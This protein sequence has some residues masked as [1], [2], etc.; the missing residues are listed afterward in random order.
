MRMKAD[1]VRLAV[2]SVAVRPTHAHSHARTRSHSHKCVPSPPAP[3]VVQAPR[4]RH[5]LPTSTLPLVSDAGTL[6]FV[7]T[8]DPSCGDWQCVGHQ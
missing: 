5:S 6:A 3:G 1:G 8:G 4:R 2:Y 7:V